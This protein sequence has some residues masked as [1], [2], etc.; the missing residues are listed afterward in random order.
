MSLKYKQVA[1]IDDDE[2]SL[3]YID[4]Q[5]TMA[6]LQSTYPFSDARM[7]LDAIKGKQIFPDLLILDLQMPGIDGISL[8][9]MLADV[10]FT[11]AIIITSG[12]E[13]KILELAEQIA[14]ENDLFLLGSL[15]KPFNQQQLQSL[16][17][18]DYQQDD[19]QIVVECGE[20]HHPLFSL[21]SGELLLTRQPQIDLKSREIVSYEVLARWRDT[22]GLI[23]PPGRFIHQLEE[24]GE[25]TKFQEL[26]FDLAL[27]K[28][29]QDVSERKYS[30]NLS[31]TS[32]S[33]QD[34]PS[35]ICQAAYKYEVPLNRITIEVTE[36]GIADDML[37]AKEVLT[38]LRLLGMVLAIDDY[39][40]GFSTLDKLCD[41][42][43]T[44]VK[45]DRR[46]IQDCHDSKEKQAIIESTVTIAKSMGLR[47][48]AEGMETEAEAEMVAS[49]S[50]D[51]AQ[52]FHFARPEIWE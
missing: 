13:Q 21:D 30:I 50:V 25:I 1:I 12:F 47:T 40:T 7:A 28:I 8:I 42:P 3:G 45:L 27:K 38:R 16:L 46:Y 9:K 51:I 20:R 2:F 24:S 26:L 44:E 10:D 22:N 6:G 48:V 29:S 33:N 19:E 49:L 34:V 31:L 5:M 35:L 14:L 43:F 15:Q 39:G 32:I 18:T 17:H 52:G 36:S 37:K 11:G 23:I 41:L 4:E